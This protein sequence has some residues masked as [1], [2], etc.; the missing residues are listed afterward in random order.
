ML[1]EETPRS[2]LTLDNPNET[3]VLREERPLKFALTEERPKDSKL[4]SELIPGD[5]RPPREERPNDTKLLSEE[6]PGS[7]LTLDNPNDTIVLREE[8]PL[9]FAATEER[10]KD[11]KL[12][13][14][15]IPGEVIP[16]R[17]DKP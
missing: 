5:V 6:T 8:R 4:L 2:L 3:I 12:L 10:P 16:P 7:L 14:E 9:K 1:S 11:S 13:S 15:L 17:E